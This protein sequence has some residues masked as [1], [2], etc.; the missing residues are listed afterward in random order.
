MTSRVYISFDNCCRPPSPP[1]IPNISQEIKACLQDYSAEDIDKK[2]IPF[3]KRQFNELQFEETKLKKQIENARSKSNTPRRLSDSSDNL[4]SSPPLLIS[5]SPAGPEEDGE[6]DKKVSPLKLSLRGVV[7]RQPSS[8]SSSADTMAERV[9]VTSHTESDLQQDDNARFPTNTKEAAT[10]LTDLTPNKNVLDVSQDLT[11]TDD[12]DL[13][14]SP[15]KKIKKPRATHLTTPVAK[16]PKESLSF[17]SVK[18]LPL[19]PKENL[20]L[21]SKVDISSPKGISELLKSPLISH[22]LLATSSPVSRPDE[23]TISAP[24]KRKKKLQL[25][26]SST[27]TN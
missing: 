1:R 11:L 10:D 2:L 13:E 6:D 3:K 5:T 7:I 8:S 18:K 9:T 14:S 16:I 25:S 20:N 24:G 15:V 21:S 26:R 17:G 27:T 19:T 23:N 4:R 12:S 22:S